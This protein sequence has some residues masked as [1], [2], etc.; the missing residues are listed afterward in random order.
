MNNKSGMTFLE[1]LIA[2]FLFTLMVSTV[3]PVFLTTRKTGLINRGFTEARQLAQTQIEW[4]YDQS[5]NLN[6][7]D[8]LYQ[9]ISSSNSTYCL[10]P[11]THSL[12]RNN[13]EIKDSIQTLTKTLNSNQ[14]VLAVVTV[15]DQRGI[16][17]T[18]HLTYY[19]REGNH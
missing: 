6:Y 2:L 13:L 16:T 4:I 14:V 8:T 15:P 5:Q 7:P 17:N 11:S 19:V 9:L 12:S 18:I 3:F 10:K 1:F